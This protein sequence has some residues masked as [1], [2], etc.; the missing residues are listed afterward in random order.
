M[1]AACIGRDAEQLKLNG[2]LRGAAWGE[3]KVIVIA[4]EPGI[5]KTALLEAFL[6]EVE[7][8]KVALVGRGQCIEPYGT[9]EVQLPIVQAL[10]G[11]CRGPQ[12]VR[13]TRLLAQHAP[14]WLPQ[15]SGLETGER[16][17]NLAPRAGGASKAHVQRELVDALD[18]LSAEQPLV[19]ALEGLHWSDHFTVDLISMLA[20]RQEP[21]KLL[22]VGTYRP[23]D[24]IV[25]AHPLRPLIL[26]LKAQGLCMELSLG[27]FSTQD[28]EHYLEA[29]F[30]QNQFSATLGQ[31]I[32]ECTDGNP[33]LAVK[34][35]DSLVTHKVVHKLDG[36]WRLDVSAPGAADGEPDILRRL[37]DLRMQHLGPML[38]GRVPLRVGVLHSLTG[39]MAWSES[40]EIDATLLAIEEIN[41]RGGVLGR[42]IQALVVDG[43]SDEPTFSRE[44]ERLITE[45]KV[46]AVFG[47]WT[48]ASRKAVLP[49][50]EK[51]DHLL[52]YP[53]QYEGMEQSANILYTG[54]A[55]NQ[56]II[57]AVRWAFGFLGKKRFFLMGWNSVYSRSANAII[58]DEINALGGE[59]VG[60]EYL[61]PNST[62]VA[63]VVRK[64]VRGKPDLIFNSLVG[65]MNVLY[66]RAL[67]AA[68]ITPEKVPTVYFSISEIELLSLSLREVLGDYAGW[69]YFQSLDRPENHAFVSR[70]RSRY[71]ASV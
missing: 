42:R 47:C 33:L 49:I 40:P 32:L 53:T 55:P 41:Q 31:L 14:T 36:H 4:G 8:Q 39:M 52:I 27:P 57:P 6:L 56:Q 2:W 28:I 7:S 19:L 11:L 65:D 20:R 60:E 48:S 59:I 64:I 69:N 1:A 15:A 3:R 66:A 34:L 70:F 9:Q 63:R 22:V 21:A 50:V 68:G 38:R 5:G 37:I 24:A 18:A 51:H 43:Q 25:T 45:E 67:R 10:G 17:A 35:V 58:R 26:E 61:L 12:G 30:P 71:G 29:R 16:P 54:A 62:D 13:I 23:A 44:A 46:C